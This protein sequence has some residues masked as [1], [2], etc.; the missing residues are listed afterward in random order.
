[1]AS[2]FNIGLFL[3]FILFSSTAY[4]Q[5]LFPD[6]PPDAFFESGGLIEFH[7]YPM[8]EHKV[9]T[10][11]GYELKLYRIPGKKGES[12]EDAVSQRRPP[13]VMQHGFQD[14]SDVF[15]VNSEISPAFFFADQGYDVWVT[16]VRGNRYCMK[17]L[18]FP[19][20]S[21][22]FWDFTFEQMGLIDLET[23]V[24]YILKETRYKKLAYIAHS[25]GTTMMFINQC[26]HPEFSDSHIASFAAW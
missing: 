19:T 1:M 22:E 18:N 20:D 5:G 12:I 26:M 13:L 14:T 25:Q 17:N 10:P 7:K 4:N 21:D 23:Y 11:D 24:K 2:Q 6:L 8:E 3:S 9:I 15:L 16:N